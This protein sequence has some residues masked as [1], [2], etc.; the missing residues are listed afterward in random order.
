MPMSSRIKAFVAYLFL[1]LGA[2]LILLIS[3]DD[4]Y[5]AF[6][7]RQSIALTLVAI[8][9]PLVWAPI[10]YVVS[11]IPFAG[12]ILASASFGLVI[13]LGMVLTI[14]WLIGMMHALRADADPLP[15]VGGV[16]ARWLGA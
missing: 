10:A 7:A 6:H 14:V 3:R 1:A 13:A 4:R 8:L 5:S 15:F 16:A 12:P 2:I 11:F 9:A